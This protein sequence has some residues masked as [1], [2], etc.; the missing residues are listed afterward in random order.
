MRMGVVLLLADSVGEE[1]RGN[2]RDARCEVRG[3]YL[4]GERGRER[5][6]EREDCREASHVILP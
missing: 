2:T 3:V 6:E 5:R 4:C 1:W